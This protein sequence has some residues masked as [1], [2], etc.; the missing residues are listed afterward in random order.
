MKR[1]FLFTLVLFV[2]TSQAQFTVNAELRTRGEANHGYMNLPTE[3]SETAFFV[4]QRTR[5][6]FN[7]KTENFNTYI[8]FQDVRLWGQEDISFR[9]GIQSSSIGVDIS[10]AWFDWKFAKNWGLKSGRQDWI[11]DDGRILINRNW[12][13]VG[14][15]WD[16]FL[17]HFDKED[18]HFHFGSSINNTFM[19]FNRDDYILE[20]NPY[21]EPL[22]YRIKYFNFIW[23]KFHISKYL[24]LSVA[25]YLASYLAAETSSTYYALSTTTLH[26][27][28]HS[29]KWK[30]LANAFY[31]YGKTSSS[32]NGNAYMFTIAANYQVNKVNMGL[33]FDYISGEK[34]GNQAFNIMY[35]ARL[36][37]NGWMNYYI[38][39]G[40]SKN[41][42][43]VD[44]YPNIKYA[45]HPKHCV[46]ATYH[47]FWLAQQTDIPLGGDYSYLNNNLGGELDISYKYK[48]DKSFNIQVH[49]GYYFATETTEFIKNIDR[50]TSTTPIWTSVMLTY[51]PE[52]FGTGK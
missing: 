24:N 48:F 31:Q 45:F 8:S 37:Y 5:L 29:E 11:Y 17:L 2:T 4:S 36:K 6:N 51:K 12:N 22:G 35:G 1:F 32:D 38:T 41:G 43:L 13:Q 10:Q 39:P 28:Y 3:N 19:S 27:D 16:A 44:L 21:E 9:T 25:E 23:L 18:F 30:I 20:E 47:F 46:Y 15:S 26:L 42:G 34:D 14:L 40:S 7:Y 50:G 49:F 33:G 52:L